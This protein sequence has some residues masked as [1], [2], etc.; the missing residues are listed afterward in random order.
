MNDRLYIYIW[1]DDSGWE[2]KL[3]RWVA[4]VNKYDIKVKFEDEQKE[5]IISRRSVRSYTKP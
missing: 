3:C 4:N 2:G 5:V 1:K